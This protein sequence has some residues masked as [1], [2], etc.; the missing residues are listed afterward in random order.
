MAF[1]FVLF[2]APLIKAFFFWFREKGIAIF[3]VGPCLY[4]KELR[5][6]P[7]FSR[8]SIKKT[9]FVHSTKKYRY[10]FFKM[11]QTH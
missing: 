6:N 3:N 4:G 5:D 10:M 7:V 11:S 9:N 1:N 2:C 8:L